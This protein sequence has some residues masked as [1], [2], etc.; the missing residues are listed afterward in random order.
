MTDFSGNQIPSFFGEMT[1]LEYLDL[2][3]TNLQGS[4]PEALGNMTALVYLDLSNNKLEGEIWKSPIWNICTL[5]TLYLSSN[6]FRGV[7]VLSKLSDH[8]S[9]FKCTYYFLEILDLS[10]NS[11]M[12]LFSN[13]TLLSSL[14]E[15]RLS[16]N[17]MNG[18]VLES[19]GKLSNLEILDLS[20]NSI[21]G[22]F[23][24][25][26]LLSSLKELSLSS[27]QLN[28]SV[29]ESVGKLSNL[30]ILY[31]SNNSFNGVV[32]ETHFLKLSKLKH[33]D[34]SWNHLILNVSSDWV[35]PFHLDDI[36]LSNCTL[37]PHFPEWL[38]TQQNCARLDI[39]NTRISESIPSWFWNSSI[40]Y[41][42]ADL[43]E[44][45]ISGTIPNSSLQWETYPEIDL[46]SNQLEGPIPLFLFQVFA[47]YLSGN[48]FSGLNCLCDVRDESQLSFLDVSHNQLSG[49][50]PNCWSN[51]KNMIV[52]NLAN[53]KLSG[54]IPTSIGS[55][56]QIEVL[57]LG[58]NNFNGELPIT[59]KNCP[60]LVVF[61][62]GHNK[63][64]GPVPTWIGKSLTKLAIVVLRSNQLNGSIPS[65]MC[66]LQ[67]LQL[68]DL[69]TN[70]ISGNIPICVGNFTEMRKTGS[71][72]TP[73]S[74]S[75]G[76]IPTNDQVE[77]VWK[78]MLFHHGEIVWKGI[79]SDHVEIV[80][81]G[82]LS[83]FGSTLRL[84]RSVDLSCNELNGEIPR[85]IT[86]LAAL[87]SLNLSTNNMSGRIPPQ[88]GSMK[89]LD[90][91]DLSDN[92]FSGHIP[93]SLGLID[94]LGVL[95]LSNN[96]LSGKIPTST[97]LQ[98]RSASSYMG[99]PRL[100]GAPLD[101]KYCPGEEPPISKPTDQ[102]DENEFISQGFYASMGAGFVVGFWGFIGTLL[103]NKT[104]RLEYFNWLNDLVDWIFVIVAV[105]SQKF[106]TALRS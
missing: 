39:S 75:F 94:G 58:N 95:N 77:I 44:N 70:H 73:I 79:L 26:T 15:L 5:R 51:F 69:S 97:Q 47:L 8:K 67:H 71:V 37:G 24:N 35:P 14:K 52:L 101:N 99:N 2:G 4:I 32:S 25:L 40:G 88:I 82:K 45:Q 41:H 6:N 20:W 65:N 10:W 33:L 30:E 100:C 78:G 87:L 53:N 28:G 81:K 59:L 106:H 56:T 55:L 3:S 91:L 7:Q 62:V 84:V 85:E 9:V 98:S 19:V 27:N 61:D 83:D 57:H 34:L 66:R 42:F 46:S 72:D 21:T 29:P 102:E 90:A 96:D 92:H 17:Q 68:L 74:H 60:E 86:Q 93:E 22:L 105:Q 12:G 23:P 80:W 76:I 89:S 48:K 43:S 104:W 16:S 36:L 64:S 50:I 1:S 38:R 103:F 54:K 31:L 63:L 13:L 49:T 11:I 18:S